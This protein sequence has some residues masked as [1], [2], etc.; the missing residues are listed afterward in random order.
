MANSVYNPRNLKLSWLGFTAKDLGADTA[1]SVT[2]N[3]DIIDYESGIDG[4]VKISKLPDHTGE[5]TLSCQMGG[6][7]HAFLSGIIAGQDAAG[8]TLIGDMVFNDPSGDAF[9]LA[10]GATLMT[11]PEY[12]YGPTATG[13]TRD[14]VFLISD[15]TIVA[16]PFGATDAVDPAIASAV[17]T[18]FTF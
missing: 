11:G 4:S 18:A 3:E 12:T 15:L 1:I 2:R 17:S 5:L 13:E 16:D 7:T 6:A 10:K 14:Y 8:K 9:F